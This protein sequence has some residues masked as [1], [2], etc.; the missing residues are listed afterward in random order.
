MPPFPG[1]GRIHLAYGVPRIPVP[2]GWSNVAPPGTKVQPKLPAGL[3]WITN[4]NTGQTKV[5][6][7][8]Q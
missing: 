4:V 3:I 1:D 6:P 8:K 5:M 7:G 2:P